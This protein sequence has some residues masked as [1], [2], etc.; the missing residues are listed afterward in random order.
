MRKKNINKTLKNVKF[1]S[2]R[3][4]NGVFMSNMEGNSIGGR[5]LCAIIVF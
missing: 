1:R 2:I 5:G 4:N 3:R